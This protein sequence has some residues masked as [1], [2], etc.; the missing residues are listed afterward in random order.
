[1]YRF[2]FSS[3]PPPPPNVILLL[4]LWA[5]SRK[6]LSPE[7]NLN[8]LITLVTTLCPRLKIVSV[9][10]GRKY[11]NFQAQWMIL[12][13][14]VKKMLLKRWWPAHIHSVKSLH[15]HVRNVSWLEGG[16]NSN[17]FIVPGA[18]ICI[19]SRLRVL[20]RAGRL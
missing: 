15:R 16:S 3:F 9:G 12:K 10:L 19:L 6:M 5:S 11:P 2:F 8:S 14:R 13:G 7:I 4:I 18:K 17:A 1:M 20:L